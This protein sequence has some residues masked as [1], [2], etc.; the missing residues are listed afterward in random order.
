MPLSRS[1]GSGLAKCRGSQSAT[2]LA[3]SRICPGVVPQQPPTMFSQ[4]LA[5][6]SCNCGANDSGVSGKPVGSSG[7]GMPAFGCALTLAGAMRESSSICDRISRGPS[8]QLIPT[9][10]RSMLDTEFQYAST[11]WP[12]SVRPLWSV[13]V[14]DSITGSRWPS[15]S[16]NDSSANNAARELSESN[17]VSTSSRSTP[18]SIKPLACSVYASTNWSY[19]TARNAGSLTSGE[20]EAVRFV[21]PSAPATKH[22]RPGAAAITA[23][24]AVR[25]RLAL[26]A[27]NS[28]ASDSIP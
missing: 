23:S 4:P 20:M 27:F 3:I 2:A 11:V 14:N 21:G 13:M 8:A 5:A 12:E 24:A 17:T 26:A 18:P 10:T 15:E 1:Q 28:C 19:V 9:L 7:S 16:N 22:C 6:Q 25:A